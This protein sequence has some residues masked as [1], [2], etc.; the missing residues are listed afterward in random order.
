M[1][2]QDRINNDKEIKEKDLREILKYYIDK[3]IRTKKQDEYKKE[4]EE[5]NKK[6]F[7]FSKT[8]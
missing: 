6:F 2:Y 1:K 8:I 4:I 7:E 3:E 5:Y